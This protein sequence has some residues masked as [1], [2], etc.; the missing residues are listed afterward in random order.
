MP[1]PGPWTHLCAV[2]PEVGRE[3][4]I[5]QFARKRDEIWTSERRPG[6][7]RRASALRRMREATAASSEVQREVRADDASVDENERQRR[8]AGQELATFLPPLSK[9][10]DRLEEMGAHLP[11]D[12]HAVGVVKKLAAHCGRERVGE[13]IDNVPRKP[14][15]VRVLR[16]F[17]ARAER[18]ADRFFVADVV[19]K[20]ERQ[21]VSRFIG[22]E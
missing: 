4:T 3:R 22:C 19:V 20:D 5:D 16:P 17:S 14:V 18:A 1:P 12:P 10:L 15:P 11:D 21:V 8:E 9:R 7:S 13:A 6:E 2:G